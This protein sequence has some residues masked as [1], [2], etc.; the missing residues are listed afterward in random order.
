[1]IVQN[2]VILYLMNVYE[3]LYIWRGH[4]EGVGHMVLFVEC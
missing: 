2:L 3:D 1:M 4:P